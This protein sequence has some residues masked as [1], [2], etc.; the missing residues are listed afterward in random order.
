[1]NIG[2]RFNLTATRRQVARLRERAPELVAHATNRAVTSAVTVLARSVSAELRLPVGTVKK[3]IRVRAARTDNPTAT[4]YAVATRIP[5]I[6][7]GARGRYPSRGKGRGVTA[8]TARRNYPHAFIA[9]MKSGH[10]GVFERSGKKQSRAGMPRQ[11]PQL[12]IYELFGPSIAHV[13]PGHTAAPIA[14][15]HEQLSTNLAHNFRYYLQGA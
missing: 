4:V 3:A 14:R 15:F 1:V 7:F 8:R 10:K 2:C 6:D 9:V 12:P 11:S 13:V 5:L